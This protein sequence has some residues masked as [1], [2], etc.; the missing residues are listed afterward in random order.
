MIAI[1]NDDA[2]RLVKSI[3][4]PLHMWSPHGV[5][6]K[7]TVRNLQIVHTKISKIVKK[8]KKQKQND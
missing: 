5:R 4:A 1:S 7:N 6:E 3:V 2:R 8:K